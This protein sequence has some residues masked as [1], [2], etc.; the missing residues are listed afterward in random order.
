M[1]TKS[2]ITVVLVAFSSVLSAQTIL[3][4]IVIDAQSKQPISSA[5]IGVTNQGIGVTTNNQGTYN[6]KKYQEILSD[7][8]KLLVGA[9]GYETIEVAATE[10]R[11]LFNKN[12]IIELDR[13][14]KTISDTQIKDVKIFWDISEGMQDR[15]LEKDLEIVRQ[16]L[17]IQK[18]ISV[19]LEVFSNKIHTIERWKRWD[20]DMV[21]FRES[22]TKN[23][24]NGPSNYSSLFFDEA[25]AVILVSNGE[26]NYGKL[27]V[28]QQKPVYVVSTNQSKEGLDYISRL[29]LYTSGSILTENTKIY[30][31]EYAKAS[32]AEQPEERVVT[33]KTITGRVTSLGNPLQGATIMI[34]GD[35]A[36]YAT[37]ADGSFK[38]PAKKGD[39][40]LVRALGMFPKGISVQDEKFLSIDM[41]PSSDQLDAVVLT[42]KEKIFVGNK[43]VEGI[44]EPNMPGGVTRLGDFYITNNDIIPNGKSVAEVLREKFKGI[45]ISYT[46]EGEVLTVFGK[47]PLWY[48]NGFK[49]GPGE[50]IP[51]YIPDNEILS[52]IVKDSPARN[53]KYGGDGEEGLQILVTTKNF[54]ADFEEPSLMAKNNDY[55]EEIPL[56][57][58]FQNRLKGTVMRSEGP[59]QGAEVLRK[60]SFDVAVTKAD[61]SFA[62]NGRDGDIL[63]VTA[64]GMFSKEIIVSNKNEYA[65]ELLPNKNYLNEVVVKGEQRTFEKSQAQEVFKY[66]P[67]IETGRYKLQGFG[68]FNVTTV[69]KEDH[70]FEQ[71]PDLR[72]A[73]FGRFESLFIDQETGRPY[74]LRGWRQ[75][76][77]QLF[78]DGQL[79]LGSV[80]RV[81]PAEIESISIKSD[82]VGI[83]NPAL[84]IDTNRSGTLKT[85]ESLL[86]KNNDYTEDLDELSTSAQQTE[87][88]VTGSRGPIRGAEVLRKGSFDT[89]LTDAKGNFTIKA[90]KGDVL[91]ISALGMFSKEILISDENSYAIKL[92]SDGD[93]LDEVEITGKEL[94]DQSID[95]SYGKKNPDAIGYDVKS[96]TAEDIK[97]NY[98]SIVDVL[99]GRF[100]NIIATESPSG[101]NVYGGR[102]IGVSPVPM[103]IDI[104][105]QIFSPE[106]VNEPGV[107]P[108][109]APIIDPSRIESI[110]IIK[111][112]SGVARYGKGAEGGVVIIKTKGMSGNASSNAKNPSAL[113][114]GN[115]Y[116]EDLKEAKNTQQITGKITNSKGPV[117][118]ASITKKGSLNEVTADNNG[119]FSIQ[120]AIG[121]ILIISASGMFSKEFLI[122][123]QDMGTIQLIPKTTDLDAIVLEG[124]ERVD[125]T[126]QTADG[127]INADKLGYS[128]ETL[129]ENDFASG[130]TTLQQL[131][132]GKVSGVDVGGG[133][134]AGSTVVYK[135]RGGSQSITNEKPPIWIVNGTPYQDPPDFLDVQQI[136]NITV[137][138]STVATSRYGSL[139]AGG[140]FLI[141]TKEVDFTA[142]AAASNQSILVS[143][144][145]Y[146]GDVTGDVEAALPEYII[147]FRE[148][149]TP[150]EQLALYKKLSRTQESPLEYYVD[151]AQY[152]QSLSPELGDEVRSDL[153]YIAR[154][155]TKAL[156]S[157]AY[158]YEVVEDTKNMVLVNERIVKIAPQEAQ[159]Y[160]DLALAYQYDKQYDKALELYINMLGEQIMGVNLDG[161]ENPLRSEL[162]R[163][164]ALYKDKIDFSR[165]PNEW[166]RADFKR[167]L[168]MVI[169]WS[170]RSVPFEFQFVN[171]DK[172]FFKWAHTLEENR[173]RLEE[174]QKYGFQ[175]EEFIIDDAPA[176]EWLINIQYLGDEG[177]YVLPPFLKY[178]VFRNYGTPQE[179]KEVRIIKLFKQVDKVTL[180]RVTM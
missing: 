123:N 152:F 132:T 119:D 70:F 65:I 102:A 120:A 23:T 22:V 20:G 91:L 40:L 178:T 121:E 31:N 51:L 176:G 57:D 142:K 80:D 141:K 125:N 38:I 94:Q 93:I 158:L 162:S 129:E 8:D 82:I 134:Y 167:D 143:G 174:E 7:S 10:V 4:G 27:P 168:R 85:Q 128:A 126:V 49:V 72:T 157:L 171:P 172:K 15:N 90:Q 21:R 164:V 117:K 114:S 97:D 36:E 30:E 173:E 47:T 137:L 24:Y 60:G 140:A 71:Y 112:L 104:D 101:F 138:K 103:L 64:L 99:K 62:I 151:A 52:V 28:S 83:M 77:V 89:V 139:A 169:D 18:N 58:S 113:V 84:F 127:K 17:D 98:Y 32:V 100:A 118:D 166:L 161:L 108:R 78:I 63:I 76:Y 9:P 131:I 44:N 86:A 79:E 25:D 155:N 160:R 53:I 165:L 11:S 116:T 150:Q 105:G 13:S 42:A 2:L 153:A 26:P 154:N 67:E 12:N 92:L 148:S 177:D 180:G 145:E 96:L 59:I 19:T 61:G 34:K 29:V 115:D 56:I 73:L 95:T 156:R 68:S 39:V 88:I 45:W 69:T 124:E 110:S 81:S 3:R 87:G 149:G 135:I 106:D 130:A 163:L 14:S 16:Y 33:T 41:L 159:S 37:A 55:T 54:R 146:T 5:K 175:T 43:I 50:P 75:E 179:T 35:L 109:G 66:G 46:A 48:V 170:D 147:R 122:E 6:Y 1:K 133:L 107:P 144:N 136:K 74:I 111:G